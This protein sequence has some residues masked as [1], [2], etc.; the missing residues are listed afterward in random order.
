MA[1]KPSP[2]FLTVIGSI[3]T[4]IFSPL[5]VSGNPV[6]VFVLPLAMAGGL[7]FGIEG[8]FLIGLG[9]S[10]L[11]ALLVQSIDLWTGIIYALAAG[12]GVSLLRVFPKPTFLQILLVLVGA[13]LL[14]ELLFDISMGKSLVLH[15]STFLGTS[16]DAGLR[17][18]V[19]I[20]L[21]GIVLAYWGIKAEEKKA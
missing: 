12:A 17:V 19:N 4:A 3:G 1:G 20:G 2:L 6:I 18:L 9:I 5:T 7:W 14:F 13:S 15:D 8:G 11:S 21:L 16:P 10:V